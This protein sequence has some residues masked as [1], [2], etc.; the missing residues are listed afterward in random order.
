MKKTHKYTTEE[1]L[2]WFGEGEWCDEPDLVT[3]EWSDMQC[4]IR[5]ILVFEQSGHAFGGH[6]CGY[7]KIPEYHAL[8]NNQNGFDFDL[9]VHGGVTFNEFF[10]DTKDWYIGFDCSHLFDV[11]PSMIETKKK[12][13]QEMKAKFP[14]FFEN[15]SILSI[16]DSSYKTIDFVIEECKKLAEQLALIK[17]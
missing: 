13:N 2:K 3:F 4:E 9:D 7:V 8:Y 11:V 17:V 16:F 15:S 1:K 10:N 5:R 12:I 6:L 14:D